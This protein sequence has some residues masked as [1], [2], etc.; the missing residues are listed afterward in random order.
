MSAYPALMITAPHPSQM[1]SPDTAALQHATAC[2]EEMKKASLPGTLQRLVQTMR[3]ST[4]KEVHF[5]TSCRYTSRFPPRSRNNTLVLSPSRSTAPSDP[6]PLRYF[7]HFPCLLRCLVPLSLS[8]TSTRVSLPHIHMLAPP[9]H[10][11]G[12]PPCRRGRCR[13]SFCAS[14]SSAMSSRG[15]RRRGPTPAS[16]RPPRRASRGSYSP[17]SPQ[18]RGDGHNHHLR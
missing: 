7:M 4:H 8:S 1:T 18:V 5:P 6:N 11:L 10:P 2:Y 16:I 3:Q 15:A 17:S 12:S 13:P 14:S 9:S